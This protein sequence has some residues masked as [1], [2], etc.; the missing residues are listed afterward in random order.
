MSRC[1]RRSQERT[2]GLQYVGGDHGVFGALALV[3]AVVGVYGVMAYM[4]TQRTHEIGVRMALGAT[5][6]TSLA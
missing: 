2:I 3:L 5:S 6:A 1:A 4:V